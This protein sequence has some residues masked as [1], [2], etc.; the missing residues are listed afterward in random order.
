MI[1]LIH[2]RSGGPLIDVA[3]KRQVGVVSWGAGCARPDKAGVY[4]RVSA[5][6]PW[7]KS[8]VCKHSPAGE[9]QGWNCES[10]T[11]ITNVATSG[12]S[13]ITSQNSF[14]TTTGGG[15]SNAKMKVTV[16][17][18]HDKFPK[19][20]SFELIDRITGKVVM[21]QDRNQ[22]VTKYADVRRNTLLPKGDYVLKMFDVFGDGLVEAEVG[23]S[24]HAAPSS[25]Y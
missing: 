10:S 6:Y 12:V 5:V 23:T 13:S 24:Q 3:T 17:V 9:A 20:V 25:S 22:V 19:E 18:R 16:R 15:S 7:I 11:G 4:A 2:L 1:S 14:G 8:Q 21:K